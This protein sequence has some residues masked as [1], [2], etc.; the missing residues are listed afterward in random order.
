[1]RILPVAVLNCAVVF[2]WPT[3]G[4]PL[5]FR[6]TSCSCKQPALAASPSAFSDLMY[7]RSVPESRIPSFVSGVGLLSVTLRISFGAGSYECAAWAGCFFSATAGATVAGGRAA[8]GAA[9]ATSPL[10]NGAG[11]GGFSAGTPF[12]VGEVAGF[13]TSA[14]GLVATGGGGSGFL[15]VATLAQLGG[16]DACGA[17]RRTTLARATRR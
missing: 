15:A 9:A 17:A 2:S 10:T 12:R 6:K 5:T 11:A 7:G 1:M 13:T 14:A 4:W 3:A 16:I 8:D